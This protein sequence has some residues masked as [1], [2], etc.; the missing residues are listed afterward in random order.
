MGSAAKPLPK[1]FRMKALLISMLL[2]TFQTRLSIAYP[3]HNPGECP[4]GWVQ[5]GRSCYKS[6]TDEVS[7]RDAQSVCES[8][9]SDLASVTTEEEGKFIASISGPNTWLG[10]NDLETE[11]QWKWVSN[12]RWTWNATGWGAPNG[13][14]NGKTNEN[15][16]V[17]WGSGEE[18]NDATCNPG[19]WATKFVCEKIDS[20]GFLVV[21]FY[22]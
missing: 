6:F 19:W 21:P 4:D 20:N 17:T 2:G 13:E 18:W 8:E 3:Q 7:W 22:G 11:G 14:P 15:C 16:L 1:L 12:T 9:G 10:G 5:L